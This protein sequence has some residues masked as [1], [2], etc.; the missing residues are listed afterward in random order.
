MT[1]HVGPC[2]SDREERRKRARADKRPVRL[3]GG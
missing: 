2:V 3:A 1:L